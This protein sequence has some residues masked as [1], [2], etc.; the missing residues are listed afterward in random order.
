VSVNLRFDQ[1]AFG[2]M[3]FDQMIFGERTFGQMSHLGRTF[4]EEWQSSANLSTTASF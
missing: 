4:D 3:A 1:T 2:Q